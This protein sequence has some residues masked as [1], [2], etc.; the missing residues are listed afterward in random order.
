[1]ADR[2][3]TRS[4]NINP[5]APATKIIQKFG[6]LTQFC[7]ATRFANSTVH[8]WQIKGL[9][10]QEHWKHIVHAATIR[11]IH[12]GPDDFIEAGTFPD[13]K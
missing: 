3:P 8:S 1:M 4:K 12:L 6:G 9:I 7:T 2:K 13:V 10:P 5:E 11:I